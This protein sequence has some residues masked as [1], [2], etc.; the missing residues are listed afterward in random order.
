[1]EK[2]NPCGLEVFLFAAAA[3]ELAVGVGRQMSGEGRVGAVVGR[4]RR[5]GRVGRHQP[6]GGQVRC[7][8]DL[9][10]APHPPP[11]MACSCNPCG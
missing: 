8:A 4:G 1:M 11:V 6:E 9:D 10:L 2:I 7:R 5:V 3:A